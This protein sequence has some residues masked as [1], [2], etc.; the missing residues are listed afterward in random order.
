MKLSTG[1]T[2]AGIIGC[3]AAL[4]PPFDFLPDPPAL[5][6]IPCSTP[7]V[8]PTPTPSA[9]VAR[10]WPVEV[11]SSVTPSSTPCSSSGIPTL[12]PTPLFFKRQ[13]AAASSTA[14]PSSTPCSSSSAVPFAL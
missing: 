3:A 12:T 7:S 4:P 9:I 2:F 6:S 14:T 13:E 1:L 8:S 11:S 5:S 10:D